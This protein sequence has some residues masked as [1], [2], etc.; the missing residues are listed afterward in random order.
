[1]VSVKAF[2]WSSLARAHPRRST[3]RISESANDP[4]G[5][6]GERVARNPPRAWRMGAMATRRPPVCSLWPHTPIAG[7]IQLLLQA[8]IWCVRCN[9]AR[10]QAMN[11]ALPNPLKGIFYDFASARTRMINVGEKINSSHGRVREHENR[12]NEMIVIERRRDVTTIHQL[13]SFK[14]TAVKPVAGQFNALVSEGLIMVV[15]VCTPRAT[16]AVRR[17]YREQG[18]D[19]LPA[20]TEQRTRSVLG[21]FHEERGTRTIGLFSPGLVDER[22]NGL[23]EP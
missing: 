11:I 14:R 16:D 17:F 7:L 9:C 4:S 13:A 10:R 15:H 20:I 3:S 1:V 6:T 5:M 8:V 12:L 21:P 2:R 19:I 23:L 22:L 18:F